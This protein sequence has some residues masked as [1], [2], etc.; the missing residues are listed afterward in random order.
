MRWNGLWKINLISAY[1][2]S[3]VP[4]RRNPSLILNESGTHIIT[5]LGSTGGKV[6]KGSSGT[7]VPIAIAGK[8]STRNMLACSASADEGSPE[9]W[10]SHIYA[11]YITNIFAQACLFISLCL[12]SLL[13]NKVCKFPR[14]HNFS[15]Y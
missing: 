6:R 15:V 9:R 3:P 2:K 8:E 1:L 7:G 12:C 4:R 14:A 11:Y 13:L 10:A 5:G